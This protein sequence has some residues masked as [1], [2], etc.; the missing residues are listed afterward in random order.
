MWKESPAPLGASPAF[1]RIA[2]P[3]ALVKQDD[4]R[5]WI[6]VARG[7]AG[8]AI[9]KIAGG[10]A[11]FEGYTDAEATNTKNPA[12]CVPAGRCLAAQRA[13][14]CGRDAQGFF[15]FVDRIGDTFRWKGENV[16]T[17]EVAAA[18]NAFPGI[19]EANV[20]GVAVPGADGRAGMAALEIAGNLDLA[21]LKAHLAARLPAYA[22]P[23]FLRIV[24]SL[25]IT[26]TFKQKKQD[27][28]RDRFS[29]RRASPI[30]S[31]PILGEG[32][33]PLDDELYA[34]ISTGRI[35]I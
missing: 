12:R 20:Y 3:V 10:A 16:A 15:Y 5:K 13:T 32:Y 8:E 28:A 19:I 34:R 23:V 6:A 30:R 31:M 14:V 7:E 27:L 24:T 1:L 35:R 18:L 9:A 21:E 25:A 22:R 26:E 29:S 11:R 33:E 4:E 17:T 2:F